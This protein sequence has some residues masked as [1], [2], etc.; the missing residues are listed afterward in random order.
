MKKSFQ[1]NTILT[2]QSEI[3]SNLT[4]LQIKLKNNY[5]ASNS[6]QIG[7]IFV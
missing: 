4:L 1:F 3:M 6:Y 2:Y 7:T 5:N